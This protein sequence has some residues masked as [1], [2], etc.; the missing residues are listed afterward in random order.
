[1]NL[2]TIEGVANLSDIIV[3]THS[4]TYKSYIQVIQMKIMHTYIYINYS[5]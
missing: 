2:I 4:N 3:A 1:M 5:T